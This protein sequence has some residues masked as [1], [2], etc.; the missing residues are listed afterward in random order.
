MRRAGMPAALHMDHCTVPGLAN[1][2]TEAGWNPVLFDSSACSCGEN[3]S[4][5]RELCIPAHK[6]GAAA[7]GSV[8]SPGDY[9]LLGII[10]PGLGIAASSLYICVFFSKKNQHTLS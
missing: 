10:C 9:S 4:I 3:Q 6:T 8:L 1:K 2:S 5:T 7:G